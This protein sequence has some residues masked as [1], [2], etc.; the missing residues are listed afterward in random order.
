MTGENQNNFNIREY[1]HIPQSFLSS[2]KIE[3]F[4]IAKEEE[5]KKLLVC[6]SLPYHYVIEPTNVCNLKC[7]LCPTGLDQSGRKK[8]K[9]QLENFKIFIDKIKDTAIELFFQ[10][11]GESTLLK[12]LPEMINYA[13]KRNIYT[14]LSSNFSTNYHDGFIEKIIKS[15]LNLLHIDLDGVTQDVYSHYRKKGNLDLVTKNLKLAIKSKKDLKQ[16]FPIIETTMLVMKHN[17]HQ[18]NEFLQLSESLGV[19]RYNLGKIQVNPNS[20]KDWL[21]KNKDFIYKTYNNEKR[22]LHCKWPWS[23]LVI[24]WDGG[25]SPCCIVD[26][27]KLDFGNFNNNSLKEIWNNDYFQSARAT[28][29]N[30]K[31]NNQ[32]ETICNICKNETHD[33][34]LKRA[35]DS[36]ALIKQN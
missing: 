4:K 12:N 14:I 24:N 8:G 36:F 19:D 9:M 23:G 2:L 7:P 31:L 3:N 28:F 16:S 17:E 15:G 25:I 20:S 11:W 21:P 13:S 1:K 35:S 22:N 29:S 5:E 10:N 33:P 6:Q 27:H 26:D 18:T 30:L 34:N 32:V